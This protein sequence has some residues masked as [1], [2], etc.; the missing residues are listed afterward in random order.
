MADGA[1]EGL[2]RLWQVAEVWIC[3]KPLEVNPT[4]RDDKAKWLETYFGEDWLDRLI[5]TPNKSMVRGD[6]LLDDAP[7]IDWLE[8]A[9]WHSVIFP[10]TWNDEG[11]KWAGMPRWGWDQDVTELL[12]LIR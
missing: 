11:S 3:T 4:C 9:V 12:R 7:H 10:T 5:I 1:V 6:I 2:N 8:H